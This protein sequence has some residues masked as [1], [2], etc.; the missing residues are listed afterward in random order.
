MKKH[1][2]SKVTFILVIL[3]ASINMMGQVPDYF[4]G[5]PEW[6]QSSDCAVGMPCIEQ[7]DYVYYIKGDSIVDDILYKKIYKHGV[8]VQWWYDSPPVP[9]SCNNSWT[10]NEFYTL[11][12]Q[13]SSKIFIRQ[14]DEEEKLLYDFNMKAGDTLPITW[15]QW[16]EN[17][18]VTS[19]DSILVGDGYRKVFH[20]DGTGSTKIIEGLG[21]DGGFLEPFPPILE[22]GHFLLCFAL[23]GTTYFPNLGDACD[24]EVNVPE[25]PDQIYLNAYPNPATNAVTVE[26]EGASG[27]NEIIAFDVAGRRSNLIFNRSDH[28]RL[29]IDLSPLKKG[30]Y[31]IQLI[32]NEK[33]VFQFKTIKE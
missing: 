5:N 2:L 12:R 32:D 28:D 23:D 17:T 19:I 26:M 20:L 21:H 9:E 27:I 31:I 3:F 7:S 4:A 30:L 14:W 13:D 24:L 10:F 1:T 33:N 6:R 29:S 25:A 11:V 15:N 16:N 22:C 18:V 8:V